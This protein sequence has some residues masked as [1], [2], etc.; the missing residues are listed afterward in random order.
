MSNPSKNKGTQAETGVTR[1]LNSNNI[2]AHRQ[3]LTGQ[4]DQ[5]DIHATTPNGQHFII[6]VKA[7]HA[8]EKASP[9]QIDQWWQDT[10]TETTNY[11]RAHPGVSPTPILVTKRP[12]YSPSR[13]G[14]WGV[15]TWATINGHRVRVTLTLDQYI[16]TLTHERTQS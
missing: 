14:Q 7:G 5:G 11:S 10:L 12:G 4:H 16:A 9:N 8:A 15:H 3:P 1:Y 13:C 2:T 6:E